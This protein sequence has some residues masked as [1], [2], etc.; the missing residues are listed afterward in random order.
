VVD[1]RSEVISKTFQRATKRP[2][3]MMPVR[4]AKRSRKEASGGSPS[5]ATAAPSKS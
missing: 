1:E 4:E 3:R 2:P 5:S